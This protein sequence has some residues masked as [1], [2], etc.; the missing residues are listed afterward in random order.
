MVKQKRI[1]SVDILETIRGQG[2]TLGDYV[3]LEKIGSGSFGIVF[4]GRHKFMKDTAA[5]KIPHEQDEQVEEEALQEALFL[6][7]LHTFDSEEEYDSRSNHIVNLINVSRD[8][9]TDL[10][11]FVMEF[12]DGE[13]LDVASGMSLP[14]K[15][16][17]IRQLA[18]AFSFAHERGLL[19]RDIKP[20]N[21]MLRNDGFLKILDFGIAKLVNDRSLQISFAGTFKYM[22][23]E[24][25]DPNVTTRGFGADMWSLGIIFYELLT[26]RHPFEATRRDELIQKIRNDNPPPLS[27]QVPGLNSDVCHLVDRM[28]IKDPDRRLSDLRELIATI[29]FSGGGDEDL[30]ATIKADA[31]DMASPRKQTSKIIVQE[32][33]CWDEEL[34]I[35]VVKVEQ[36]P[37]IR[38]SRESNIEWPSKEVVLGD[39]YISK[40]PITNEQYQKYLFDTQA[41]P[42][43]HWK[44]LMYP[45]NTQNH[46][47]VNITW[48]DAE[49]FCRWMTGRLERPV[50]LP[51]EAE[52]EKAAR[53]PGGQL[54]PWGDDP[55]NPALAN[56]G[57]AHKKI[58]PVDAYEK[59]ASTFGCN[60]M[61]GNVWEWCFDWFS[62]DF[63]KR[64]TTINPKGPSSG[65]TKVLRGGSW[66]TSEEFLRC[67]YRGFTYP[68]VHTWFT[69]GFR[70]VGLI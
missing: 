23:P 56:Y 25:F 38:G 51:T 46:P 11:Y 70:C 48:Y 41:A 20:E 14:R 34:N 35:Q 1:D 36:G 3:A 21:I 55:P 12:V 54:F 69:I 42:P 66:A 2:D 6:K 44:G 8:S 4:K 50:R 37:F 15:L 17:I 61:V 29:D 40:Y 64:S 13:P 27:I 5:I 26:E 22:A 53:G 30:G 63:Y 59:G 49:M 52:W 32:T 39:Y 43:S 31:I 67:S 18:E 24:M 10:L 57:K 45:R 33:D 62:S 9:K 68:P 19:H 58:M 7:R 60:Q 65:E 47:V 16:D 28:L